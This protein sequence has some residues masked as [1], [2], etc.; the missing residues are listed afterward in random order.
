MLYSKC[1]QCGN[2]IQSEKQK[3]DSDE[4]PCRKCGGKLHWNS[5]KLTKKRLKRVYHYSKWLKCEKCRTAYFNDEYRIYHD[6]VQPITLSVDF[7]C[8]SEFQRD[9][10]A[11]A[12]DELGYL[13]GECHKGNKIK[14]YQDSKSIDP[15]EFVDLLMPETKP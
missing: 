11:R 2:E 12:L 13:W 6:K 10:L 9:V 1:S 15:K 8:G 4:E 3:H 5:S 14:V 7:S